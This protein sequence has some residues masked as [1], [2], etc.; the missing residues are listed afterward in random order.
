MVEGT[1]FIFPGQGSQ[2]AGMS[3]SFYDGFKC[4][5]DLF[6]EADAALGMGLA[7][8]IMNGPAE[9]LNKTAVTQPALLTASIAAL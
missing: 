3:K 8:I 4:A 5:R 7:D 1:A 2:Y 6:N 9:E